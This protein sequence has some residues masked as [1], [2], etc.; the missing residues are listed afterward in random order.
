MGAIKKSDVIDGNVKTEFNKLRK[1]VQGVTKDLNKLIAEAKKSRAALK[2]SKTTT[3]TLGDANSKLTA[4]NKKLIQVQKNLNAIHKTGQSVSSSYLK[5]LTALNQQKEKSAVS[6]RRVIKTTSEYFNS[7]KKLNEQKKKT[8]KL[9]KLEQVAAESGAGS[10]KRINLELNNNIKKYQMLSAEQR[11]NKNIGGQLIQSI[12]KQDAA[13]KKMDKTMGRSQRNVGNYGKAFSGLKNLMGAAGVVGGLMMFVNVVKGAVKT[14][15]EF[16]KASSNLAAVLG[17]TKEETKALSDDA[18]RLGAATQY[19]A[20][21]I[22]NLQTEYAKLGFSQEQII[23]LTEATLNLATASGTDLANAASI[24]GGT[25]RAFGMDAE[26]TGRATDVMAAAF[27]GSA[28]DIEKFNVGMRTAAPFAKQAGDSIETATAK[29]GILANNSIEASSA[30]T[31]LRNIYI[32]LAKNGMTYAEAMDEINNSTN[33]TKTATDLF[34]KKTAGA[35]VILAESQE[36]V[37][38][39][40]VALYGA[41]GAAKSM[42]DV[43]EDNLQGDL[44]KL[45]SAWDGLILS[46][47]DGTGVFSELSRATIQGLTNMLSSVQE[48][49]AKFGVWFDSMMKKSGSFRAVIAGLK[50]YMGIAF[51]VMLTPI[52][53]LFYTL[54]AVGEALMALS[55][56]DY[57][58]A[59]KAFSDMSNSISA[60]A[61]KLADKV[62]TAYADMKNAATEKGLEDYENAE[63]EKTAAAELKKRLKAAEQL[64]KET[65]KTEKTITDRRKTDDDGE[66]Q[67]DKAKLKRIKAEKKEMEDY[68]KMMDSE[69]KRIIENE[70]SKSDALKKLRSDDDADTVKMFKKRERELRTMLANN[71]ISEAEYQKQILKLNSDTINRK[72]S[73]LEILIGAEVGT[74]EE[75]IELENQLAELKV[76]LAENGAEA[77]AILN[78]EQ[79]LSDEEAEAAFLEKM[80]RYA[81]AFAA[82]GA[83]GDRLFA[84]GRANRETEISE[85]NQQRDAELK[86]AGDNAEKKDA[87]NKKYAEKENQIKRKQAEADRKQAIFDILINTAVAIVKAAPS[88]PFMAFA[89]VIGALELGIVMS[90]PLPQFATG[91]RGFEGGVAELGERGAEL[92]RTPNGSFIA[93]HGLYNLPKGSDVFTNQESRRM[94]QI[95]PFINSGEPTD[96]RT[97]FLLENIHSAIKESPRVVVNVN[98]R[99]IETMR[100]SARRYERRLNDLIN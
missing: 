30:G 100:G 12:K 98:R 19:T 10:Y 87:I 83:I 26:E 77:T 67:R 59:K 70:K 14:V 5:S 27:S 96:D 84:I 1:S 86:A 71:L 18:K 34:G 91:V 9:S 58:G 37:N 46:M 48:F 88:I 3:D 52:K 76:E 90:T 22:T 49:G 99:G 23:G 13:L 6:T 2:N 16:S 4:E 51:A 74:K 56:G 68:F 15:M 44:A 92:V 73:D 89:A 72:I 75:Q 47:E 42:A 24:V 80:D 57:T 41:E 61:N 62:K 8:T 93:E 55:D 53:T 82:V 32:E 39:L 97:G 45:G 85:L 17:A 64:R 31:G 25:M 7:L 94:L 28:L 60:D 81:Q 54:K 79:K 38:A 35:A 63:R 33:K 69:N 36:E 66:K 11:K 43:M 21:E 78:E 50:D 95:N 40:A 20:T 29:L 65:A